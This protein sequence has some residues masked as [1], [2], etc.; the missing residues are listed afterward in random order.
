MS[1]TF[2]THLLG[3]RGQ[4]FQDLLARHDPTRVLCW[5]IDVGKNVQWALGHDLFG[6]ILTPAFSWP[7]S[8][9]GWNTML[10]HL[11]QTAQDLSATLILVAC[12]PTGIYHEPL[13]TRF[14][15]D[16][17]L[18]LQDQHTPALRLF[19]TSP[20][21][22]QRNREQQHLRLR[23]TDP[24]DLGAIGDLLRRG[25]G[26]PVPAWSPDE[27]RTR[28][29]LRFLRQAHKEH[30]R[31][32]AR[33]T[34]R[35]DQL[36]PGLIGNPRQVRQ[37]HPDLSFQ[38]LTTQFWQRQFVQILLQFCP[39]PY[40][41]LALGESGLIALFHQHDARCG[42]K[43]AQK[44]LSAFDRALLPPPAL[45]EVY[46]ELATQ[47]FHHLYQVQTQLETGYAHLEA[48]LPQT[49]ARFPLQI[50]GVTPRL[51][52][53]HYGRLAPV[54]RWDE[55]DQIWNHAGC[56]PSTHESGNR[57]RHGAMSKQG[58]PGW[59]DALFHLGE[60]VWY[61]CPY[62][63]N[64]YLDARQRGQGHVQA[65]FHTAHRFNRVALHL[66]QQG[67]DFAPP[68]KD[69]AQCQADFLKRREQFLAQR[70]PAGPIRPRPCRARRARR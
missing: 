29:E 63:G 53:P 12:E 18:A 26:T 1:T 36:W 47:E 15:S 51:L 4:Q 6:H 44:I 48:A 14:Q 54:E 25:L 24:L 56:T 65:V 5:P 58:D 67:E 9:A 33:L 64:T 34:N 10:Q 55:A 32:L 37:A 40:Q 19:F 8:Q 23:K 43:T 35:L 66:M 17:S 59:R 69:Y 27:I 62:F 7:T 21:Q 38:P 41:A 11:T 68:V 61:H 13:I 46:A 45:A 3:H 52:A 2:S 49:L 28:E 70:K 30:R 57:H 20:T 39:N 31:L 16:F 22:T 50:P 60:A 42:P